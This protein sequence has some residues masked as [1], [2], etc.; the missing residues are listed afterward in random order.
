MEEPVTEIQK[1][2]IPFYSNFVADECD[3]DRGLPGLVSAHNLRSCMFLQMLWA[4][5]LPPNL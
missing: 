1:S 4:S 3:N 5:N 2:P